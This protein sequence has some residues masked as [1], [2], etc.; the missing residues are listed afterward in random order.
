MEGNYEVCFGNR[1]CGKVQVL[2]QGLYYCFLCRCRISGD[3]LCRLRVICG[4]K[5]EELGVLVPV[6]GGF[7]LEKRIPVKRLGEGMPEFRLY[8]KQ[9]SSE[10]K[11]IPIIPEEPFSYI[12]RL[13]DAYL[14]CRNGQAGILI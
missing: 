5:Q 4:E 11:F 6:E 8:V 9:E 1:P 10:G 12:A 3:V 13:K 14:V 7:G 2:R